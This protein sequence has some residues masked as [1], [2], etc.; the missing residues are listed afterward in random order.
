MP[1]SLPEFLC[2]MAA[3]PAL[4]LTVLLPLA[5]LLVNG[6]TDAPNAIAAAVVTGALPFRP[7]VGLAAL[8]ILLNVLDWGTLKVIGEFQKKGPLL[9]AGQYLY[10]AFEVVLVL[11]IAAFGQRFWEAL[12]KGRSRFPFGGVVL[13]CTWGAIHMLS[14]GSLSTGLG[15][16]A[17]GLMYG[18]I[19]V[20]LGRDARTSYLAM[21]AA[22]VI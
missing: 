11:L 20:L 18:A 8:C 14:R 21:L 4:T 13:C 5:V 22:F 6:W 12:R 1:L 19:Y 3:S 9:F 2:Q 10:Y 15:V 16:M 17:F 7:A